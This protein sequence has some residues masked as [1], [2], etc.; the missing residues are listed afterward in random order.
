LMWR[1][2]MRKSRTL[3][4]ASAQEQAAKIAAELA[5]ATR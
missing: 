2:W 1:S 3:G 4:L 5:A